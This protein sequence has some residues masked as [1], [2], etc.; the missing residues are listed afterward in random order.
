[1]RFPKCRG[2]LPCALLLSAFLLPLH[3]QQNS[4]INGIVTDPAGNAIVGAQVNLTNEG[5]GNAR[6][7][8]T[9][10]AGLFTFPALNVGSYS[11]EVTAQ[12]FE[13]Y[14]SKGIVLNVSRTLRSDVQM[15]VGGAAETVTVQADALTVQTDSNVVS[16]LINTEQIT[17]IATENRNFAA[18]AALGLG[19]SSALPDNNTPT[20]VAANFTISINGLRQSHNIWLI[21]GSEADD[22]G[23]AGGMDIMPSQDAIAEFQTLSSNY[24]PDYGISSGATITLAFKSGGQK[25]S[26]EL[27]EFNRNTLFD[28]NNWFNKNSSTITPRQKLNYN[29]FGGNVGGPLLPFQHPRKTFFFWNEEWRRLIQGSTP[30]LV[31]TLPTADFPTAGTNLTYVP[32]AFAP[33]TTL[34]VPNVTDPAFDAKLAADGLTPGGPFPGNVIPSNLFDPNALLYFGSGVIPKPSNSNDQV[35]SQAETPIYVRDDI[36][37]IDHQ[38][39]SKWQLMGHYEHNSVTQGN[40]APMLGWLAYSY[41][42]VT[43]TLSNPSNT[44]AIKLSG[45]INPSLLVEASMNYDGNTINITNSKNSMLPSGWTVS[46]FFNNGSKSLP[47]VTAF[48]APYNTSEDMGSAPWHNAAQDYE[49]K[50]DISWTRGVHAFKF[51]FSYNRYTKNQ[52]LFGDPEGSLAFNN[53]SG[54]GMMDMLMGIAGSYSEFQALPIRHYVNQTP[55]FYGNDNWHVRRNLSLQLGFRYDALPHAWE[56][57]NDVANFNPAA[58]SASAM[59]LWNAD[60]SM[61]PAGPGFATVNGTPFYLNGMQLANQNGTPRGLVKNDYFTWQPRI[62]FSWDLRGNGTSVLRGGGGTFYERMQGNDIYNAATSPPF[63]YNPKASNVYLSDPHTS[64]VTGSTAALPFFPADGLFNMA[65]Y[66]PAP[67]VAQ[68]SLGY[69]QQL[70]PS[71]IWVVQYVGNTAWNQNVERRINN[72]PLDTPMSVRMNAGD[73]SNKSGTNPGGSSLSNP[74]LYRTYQGYGTINQ[75]ENTTNGN[76]NGFQTGLRAQ[77]KHGLTGELDYTW[78]HEIDITS[79]DLNQ[80]SNPF[81]LKYDKGSGALDR[82]HIL[83]ANY[84][85]ALPFLLHNQGLAGSL[86]GGWQIAGVFTA[87]SGTIINNQGPGLSLGYDPIGLGGDY[88]NRPDVSARPKYM[89]TP[90]EWFD[91]SVFTAPT[92]AWAGG[93]NNGFGNASKDIALGPGRT[94]FDTSLYKTFKIR[95]SMGFEFR[96]ESFNTF[97]HTEFNG[98][99][100]NLGDSKFGQATSTW[101][102]RVLQ[103]GGKFNF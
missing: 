45:T 57:S 23:G 26:G 54:D 75:E 19:V 60:G 52:Q 64:W 85:Y 95:E 6:T 69:Q 68:F 2:V 74:N 101:D 29:I 10:S 22:R 59:P 51:G 97:N 4:E 12:G 83:T 61:N 80:V 92:P 21:D 63:A 82:R 103:L 33:G 32:P 11:L 70:A 7:A 78:S 40:A 96:A 27:W 94:N 36:A 41:N 15:K 48:G 17:H 14:T 89:K 38:L 37:R 81:N 8:T 62:G 53:L 56:R 16:S 5:T 3:A 47:G 84:I 44:A 72:F 28:A 79:Y 91:T 102:P 76:Y 71:V 35:V 93:A 13:K 100:A 65:Q 49:P 30:T 1:M 25:Y 9:D 42:T 99:G 98:I 66:Y 24:P 86:L 34:T 55:S 58:Y 73:P 50:V 46:K 87:E 43:S 90:K 67:A 18:L 39:F 20:S 31:N 88:T 77:N